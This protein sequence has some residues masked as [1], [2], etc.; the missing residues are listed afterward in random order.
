[1]HSQGDHVDVVQRDRKV[2]PEYINCMEIYISNQC[3]MSCPSCCVDLASDKPSEIVRLT[4]DQLRNA[5]DLFMDPKEVPYSAQKY[6]VFAGGETFLDYPNLIKA[7]RH[8]QKFPIKPRLFMYTNGSFVK[9][10]WVEELTSLNTMIIFSLDGYKDENDLYRKYRKQPE[11]SAWETVMKNIGTLPKEGCGT[12]TVLRPG[13]L[14]H[15][16]DLFEIFAQMGFQ[17]VDFWPDYFSEWTKS[18]IEQL[19][20]AMSKFADYYVGRTMRDGHIP[21]HTP[22]IHHSLINAGALK[23]REV[24]WKDCFR[25][26]LAADGQFYDCE[27]VMRFRPEKKNGH[28]VIGQALEKTVDWE[29]R[30]DYMDEADEYLA[31]VGAEEEWQHVCPRLYYKI[32]ERKGTDPTPTSM[33]LHDVSNVFLKGLLKIAERLKDHPSFD[34]EYVQQLPVPTPVDE[35][36]PAAFT[37]S[38]S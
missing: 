16:I 20:D 25:L 23:R 2:C 17:T 36:L 35:I 33:E 31:S 18:D 10:E 13:N 9:K 8:C 4:W 1:M 6:L 37:I 27:G 22:M 21:F 32:G 15:L 3:N 7:A 19:D 12:N 28:S 34:Q 11:I 5:I 30:Q 24:W 14:A 38:A 29:K 26:I